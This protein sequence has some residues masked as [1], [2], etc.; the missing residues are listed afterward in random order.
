[1][2]F[3]TK[4][5]ISKYSEKTRRYAFE[6][7]NDLLTESIKDQNSQNSYDV[8]LSHSVKDAKIVL[9]VKN[10][11]EENGMKVY[12]D[13]IDDKQ[14]DRSHVTSSTAEVLRTRMR[15]SSALL[16]IATD[17]SSQSKWMPWELGFFD[18]YSVGKVAILPILSS[19]NDSFYGQEYLGLYPSVKNWT[20]RDLDIYG[21]DKG[22]ISI[23]RKLVDLSK[24]IKERPYQ[25]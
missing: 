23:N 25:W 6:S 15:Q 4:E 21:I 14:L 11:L 9:G 20:H 18:G 12:V 17:N 8:F 10:W 5:F 22:Y 3:F 7:Y 2:A 19:E 16:Y 13:W 24:F 1:M